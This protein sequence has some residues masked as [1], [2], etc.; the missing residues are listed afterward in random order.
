MK[1]T[2]G[3]SLGKKEDKL[4]IKASSTCSVIFED[5][6]IPKESMLGPEG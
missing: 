3:L 5:V 2:P 6:H 4:G 1:N